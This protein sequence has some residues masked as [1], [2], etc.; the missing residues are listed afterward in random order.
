MPNGVDTR[1]AVLLAR[2]DRLTEDLKRIK[3]LVSEKAIK[4]YRTPIYGKFHRTINPQLEELEKLKKR[5]PKG[6][7]GKAQSI[8]LWEEYTAIAQEVQ[9]IS[10]QCLDY[11][12]GIAVRQMGLDGGTCDLA[13]HLVKHYVEKTGRDWASVMIVGRERLFD[14]VAEITQ[15]IRVRF[16]EWDISSLPF[17]AQQFGQLLT[18][19]TAISGLSSFIEEEPKRISLLVD[20]PELA[21]DD[22]LE[23]D[24]EDE[25]ARRAELDELIAAAKEKAEEKRRQELQHE[26]AAA[27]EEADEERLEELQQQITAAQDKAEQNLLE[28]LLAA[29]LRA[30]RQAYQSGQASAADLDAFRQQ[31]AFHLRRLFAD[32][33]ATFFLGP[34]YLYAHLFLRVVPIEVEQ[35]LPH[36]PCRARRVAFMWKTLK[37]MNEAEKADPFQPG[38]Y[39]DVLNR[40]ESMWQDTVQI[41][42]PTCTLDSAFGVPYDHWF[43]VMY[44][45]LRATLIDGV[46]TGEQWTY[47]K[48]LGDKLL[49]HKLPDLKPDTSLPVILNAAWHCRIQN[50][51]RLPDIERNA[52]K[53]YMNVIAKPA[54]TPTVGMG[55]APTVSQ[56]Q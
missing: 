27:E 51:D 12:G 8:A 55:Q 46:F 56:M 22:L 45:K 25:E 31:Q 42:S 21:V 35:S 7:L 26:I 36:K 29:D 33:F 28:S 37:R 43:S 50:P 23:P 11:L 44:G 47:S 34:A 40:V 2:I 9:Q 1:R 5:V 3:A 16:P 54:P 20:K 10:D 15:I 4:E 49:E 24:V 38:R 18:T 32:A 53:L 48:E 30:L 6:A 17:T 52:R 39:S 13:E 41:V 19:G 14:T